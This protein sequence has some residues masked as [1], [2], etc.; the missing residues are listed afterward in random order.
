MS[1]PTRLFSG[2]RF[3]TF[4][5]VRGHDKLTGLVSNESTSTFEVLPVYLVEA[6]V[7]ARWMSWNAASTTSIAYQTPRWTSDAGRALPVSG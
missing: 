1:L 2:S 5:A 6:V 7:L 4:F 3:S